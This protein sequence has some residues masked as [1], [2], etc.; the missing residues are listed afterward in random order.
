VF[1]FGDGHVLHV[2]PSFAPTDVPNLELW[3]D[4]RD[5]VGADGAA[6]ATWTKRAGATGINATQA[7]GARQPLIKSGA[8]GLNGQPVARFDGVNDFMLSTLNAGST[9]FTIYIVGRTGGT[10]QSYGVLVGSG[11][12]NGQ[13]FNP[14]TGIYWAFAR[15]TGSTFG[16]GWGGPTGAVDL[17]AV[18]GLAINQAFYARYRT[19]KIAWSIDGPNATTPADT[20]FPTGTFQVTIGCDGQDTNTQVPAGNI[21]D[22]IAAILIYSAAVSDPNDALIK[23]Y[24][25]SVWGV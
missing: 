1:G 17:G 24:C 4:G 16:A 10:T 21:N 14:T 15:E 13:T 12:Q 9:G 11:G 3:L 20:S 8:N 18:T 5:L 2:P 25:N 22:D 23:T 7:T 6:I 19:N